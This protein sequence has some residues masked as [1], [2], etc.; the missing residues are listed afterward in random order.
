M[1][2]YKNLSGNSGIVRYQAIAGAIT[3]QFHDGWKYLYTDQSVGAANIV[4]MQ[5]LAASGRGLSTFI[6]QSIREKYVRKW[7]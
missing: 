7:Q 5:Q 1:K 3:V 2:T 4:H 6:A